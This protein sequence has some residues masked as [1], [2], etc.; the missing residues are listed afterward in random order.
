MDVTDSDHKPVRCILSVEIARVDESVRRQEFGEIIG[1]N[2]KIKCFLEELSN[3]PETI[4]STNNIILQNEDTSILRITNKCGK[5]RALFE[6]ICE[7]QSTIKDGGQSST[8]S[9]LCP[10]GS[11]GFPRW[12]EVNPAAGIIEAGHIAEISVHHYEY[13]TLE[14][15][16]DGVPQNWWC[17]DARD[18]EVILVVKVMGGGGGPTTTRSHRVRVRHNKT[19]IINNNSNNNDVMMGHNKKLINSQLPNNNN[20][21]D[22]NNSSS[23]SNNNNNNSVLHRSDFQPFNCSSDVVHHLRNLHSP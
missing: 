3:V 19:I 20:N 10:R 6:I 1:C 12:L 18:K 14:E 8:S 9:D 15:Y 4:V 13:E 23:S 16:V 5:D 11:F 17:E 21:N 7:G 22:D 2:E